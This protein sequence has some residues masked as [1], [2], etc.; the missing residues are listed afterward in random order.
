MQAGLLHGIEV[1]N[2]DEFYP[3]AFQWCLDHNLTLIGNSDVHG[4]I[5]RD[6]AMPP[7]N[8]RP[9]TWVLAT[10]HSETAIKEALFDRRTVV[11][12][13]NW[14]IGR[15]PHLKTIFDNAVEVSPVV[16]FT[17]P[18]GAPIRFTNTSDIDFELESGTVTE[19]FSVP[20]AVHIPAGSSVLIP[21]RKA[22][23]AELPESI[24]VEYRV[25][26]LKIAP[27]TSLPVAWEFQV[28]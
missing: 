6:Y 9:M 19:R 11:Y 24:T 26:N 3:R 27:E 14:L 10:D 18:Q 2:S 17:N 28:Q 20:E 23:G 4:S 8:H 16:T 1:V 25:T 13:R 15:E 7:A 12:W 22:A 21:L 5:A